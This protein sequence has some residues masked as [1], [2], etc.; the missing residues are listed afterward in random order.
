MKW[1]VAIDWI[2]TIEWNGDLMLAMKLLMECNGVYNQQ[3]YKMVIESS[4]AKKR[5]Y[6]GQIMEI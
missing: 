4:P 6:H 3:P 2:L 1:L 5:R